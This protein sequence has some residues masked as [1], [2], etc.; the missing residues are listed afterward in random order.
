MT[1]TLF[2]GQGLPFLFCFPRQV[3]Q[4]L[5]VVFLLFCFQFFQ[6][7]AAEALRRTGEQNLST[8]PNID[9]EI[10]REPIGVTVLI[11]PWN[12]PM[13][14]AANKLFP[15]VITGNTV[16]LKPSPH[17]PLTTVMMGEIAAQA[18]PPG[19]MNIISG[20]NDL[21]RWIVEHPDIVHISFTGSAATC[22]NIMLTAAGT[23]KKLTLEHLDKQK[24]TLGHLDKNCQNLCKNVLS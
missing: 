9:V 8:R 22:K 21:G 23:L 20:G 7:Y 16:V 18:F 2:L 13:S 15:A 1:K 3:P 6:F 17:T 14:M 4:V 24:L 19:V 5:L 11:T 12:F 10:V